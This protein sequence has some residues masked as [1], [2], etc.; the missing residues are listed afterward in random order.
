MAD[1]NINIKTNKD[2][3]KTKVKNFNPKKASNVVQVAFSGT[4]AT[5]KSNLRV[6][7]NED[8][9]DDDIQEKIHRH[10]I[11]LILAMCVGLIVLSI[12]AV[13]ALAAF[14]NIK[15]SGYDIINSTNKVDT[16]TAEYVDYNGGYIRYSN[17]GI[18]YYT[19]KNDIVW[20]QTYEMTNP[21]VKV[22]GKAVAVGDINGSIIYIFNETGMRGTVDTSLSI[23]QVEV[24]SQGLVAAVLE[25][26]NAN[27]I[28]LYNTEDEKIYTVKT[29]IE[30]DGYPLDVSIS[31]DATKL[32]ASYVYISG[33][34]IKTNVVFYNFSEVGQNE[35][36]RVVGGFNQYDST[37]VPDVEFVNETCAIAI[38]ENVLSI[39]KIKEYPSLSKEIAIDGEIN[40][41]F[42]S[43]EYIGIVIK[44]AESGDVYKMIVYDVSGKQ[45]FEKAFSTE[46]KEIKFDGKSIIM[47]NDTLFT[48]L[49]IKG[50]TQLEQSFD[51]PVESI[52]SLGTKGNYMLVS[53]KYIQ[54]IKLK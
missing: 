52:L 30:K 17:D 25:D 3:E 5:D 29:T 31:D 4:K 44:N 54:E 8:E 40:R 19:Q 13:V 22:C 33:N 28:N 2:S 38:G 39:Y 36:E 23:A 15:Y 51:L 27:Y 20:N 18:A 34:S 11:R 12:L 16:E 43:N 46:Y 42:V 9:A 35:T 49:N 10:R 53:S 37:L 14:E 21:Q 6:R 24:S 50:R 41:V 26:V 32:V 47:Y 7:L 48:L 1:K 45:L